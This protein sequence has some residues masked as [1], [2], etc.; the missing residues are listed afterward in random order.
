MNYTDVAEHQP[1]L[2]SR[3]HF[4]PQGHYESNALCLKKDCVA[5]VFEFMLEERHYEM[6]RETQN[7]TCHQSS[8][9]ALSV[10][11]VCFTALHTVSK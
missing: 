8:E 5:D 1:L 9:N 3:Y 6:K 2:S 7:Y 11:S 4:H 10:L